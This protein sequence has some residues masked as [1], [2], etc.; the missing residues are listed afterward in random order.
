GHKVNVLE[1]NAHLFAP[2]LTKKLNAQMRVNLFGH[3]IYSKHIDPN[4]TLFSKSFNFGKDWDQPIIEARF[5]AGPIP[6]KVTLGI[7]AHV[8]VHFY[9]GLRPIAVDGKVKPGLDTTL[10]A[11]GG[12]DIIIAGAGV[13]GELTLLPEHVEVDASCKLDVVSTHPQFVMH[14]RGEN[15]LQFLSGRMYAFAYTYVPQFGLPPWEK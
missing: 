5:M 12:P 6:V 14:V 7:R 4:S 9:I 15:H 11:S 3:T 10:Y 1:V 2:R 13:A 8:G